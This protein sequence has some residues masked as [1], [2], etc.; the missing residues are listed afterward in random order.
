MD[1]IKDSNF[2]KQKHLVHDHMYHNYGSIKQIIL[3]NFTWQTKKYQDEKLI[4]FTPKLHI[5]KKTWQ[6]M[7]CIDNGY[8]HLKKFMQSLK[9]IYNVIFTFNYIFQNMFSTAWLQLLACNTC[10][11]GVKIPT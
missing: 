1:K 11:P 6:F 9:K 3:Q 4:I 2:T 10:T 8:V 5:K 7:L